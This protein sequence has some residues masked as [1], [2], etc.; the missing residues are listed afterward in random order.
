[1][2]KK[3]ATI[4]LTLLAIIL[5]L[6]STLIYLL[7]STQNTKTPTTTQETSSRSHTSSANSDLDHVIA[8]SGAL[9]TAKT[10]AFND[11]G[12][13][14]PATCVGAAQAAA[15]WSQKVYANHYHLARLADTD[16]NSF[17][18]EVSLVP[19]SLDIETQKPSFKTI[20]H[21]NFVAGIGGLR[22]RQQ[23][24]P[25]GVEED[26]KPHTQE[27]FFQLFSCEIVP[28]ASHAYI[29]T[30]VPSYRVGLGLCC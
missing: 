12:T 21:A 9:K 8:G 18:N 23:K 28:N 19:R 4:I 29:R 16:I 27:G 5:V 15:E 3:N 2:N 22:E 1:M 24:E 6:S 13:A 14:Y 20:G 26:G 7:T 10:K 11:V 30:I 17:S 25:W